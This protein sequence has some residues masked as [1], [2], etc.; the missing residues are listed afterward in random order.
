MSLDDFCFENPQIVRPPIM[1]CELLEK[2]EK[3]D[4]QLLNKKI[5]M[6]RFLLTTR[7]LVWI[8]KNYVNIIAGKYDD[9]QR[10]E[11][12]VVKPTSIYTNEEIDELR[13]K[14]TEEAYKEKPNIDIISDYFVATG[15]DITNF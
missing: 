2:A 13:K 3:M 8:L 1:K 5:H 7:S 4:F 12:P 15:F 10:F 14:A 11:P 9:F 6:S